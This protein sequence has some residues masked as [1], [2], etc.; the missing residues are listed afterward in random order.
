METRKLQIVVLVKKGIKK[1]KRCRLVS[2]RQHSLQRYEKNVHYDR[3]RE[4]FNKRTQTKSK[5]VPFF[6]KIVYT[7]G[8]RTPT[9][10]VLESIRK[11]SPRNDSV[12]DVGC[13]TG[14]LIRTIAS[15]NPECKTGVGIDFAPN[16]IT[17]AQTNTTDRQ[18]IIFVKGDLF[19]LPF[20]EKKFDVT[21]CVNV[22]HHLHHDDLQQALNELLRVTNKYLLI[23]IRNKKTI[24]N[25][26]YIPF[27]LT[28]LYKDLPVSSVSMDEINSLIVPHHFKLEKIRGIVPFQWGCRSIVLLYKRT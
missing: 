17:S 14:E 5:I 9:L 18:K 4:Y 11:N 3:L 6:E 20:S 13:G 8:I 7:I 16:V 10:S 1:N 24:F 15:R 25:F 27:F 23:E 21:I 19:H 22:L 28:L 12:I 2:I 26:G